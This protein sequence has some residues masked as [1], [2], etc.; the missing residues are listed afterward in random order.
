MI[1]IVSHPKYDNQSNVND[2]SILTLEKDVSFGEFVQ[3]VCVPNDNE[4]YT[5]DNV[6]VIGWGTTSYSGS[7]SSVL[8]EVKVPVWA[9]KD[10]QNIY[11]REKITDKQ[12]CAGLVQGGADSCQGDSGGPLLRYSPTRHSYEVIGVVSYGFRCAEANNPGNYKI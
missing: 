10:C 7:S 4:N 2:I 1:N 6:T 8:R 3:P 11:G 5:K 12:L 9:L